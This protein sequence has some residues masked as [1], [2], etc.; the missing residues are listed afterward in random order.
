MHVDYHSTKDDSNDGH[1]YYSHYGYHYSMNR[2]EPRKSYK[3]EQG[4]SKLTY[5]KDPKIP[6]AALC[7]IN[8][9]DHTVGNVLRM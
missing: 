4:E 3:L 5:A 9:E 1:D 7:R 2:P 6:N 8:R